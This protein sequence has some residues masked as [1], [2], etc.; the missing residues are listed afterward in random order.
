VIRRL[1]IRNIGAYRSATVAFG[2]GKTAILGENGAGKSTLAKCVVMA[3]QGEDSRYVLGGNLADFIRLGEDEGEVDL[4]FESGGTEYRVRRKWS[5]SG[6]NEAELHLP[7]ATVTGITNVGAEI[8]KILAFPPKTWIDIVWAKQGEITD[9]LRGDKDVFDR[10]LGIRD[11]EEA[12]RR[13]REVTSAIREDAGR[14]EATVEQL[15]RRTSSEADI[16]DHIERVEAERRRERDELQSLDLEDPPEDVGAE[17]A[18]EAARGERIKEERGEIEELVRKGGECPTCGQSIGEKHRAELRER[19]KELEA[20]LRETEER[21]TRLRE[22]RDRA[23]RARRENEARSRRRARLEG[24]LESSGELLAELRARAEQIED[25]KEEMREGRRELALLEAE[26]ETVALL[27]EA[28]RGAQPYL[29]RGRIRRLER[30]VASSFDDMFGGRFSD[31]R[32]DEE[33]RMSVCEQGRE[34]GVSTVSGGESVALA[35]ALRLSVVEE[36]GGQDLLI[37][38]EP[39]SHL[40]DTRVAQLSEVL[41]RLRTGKQ[42][43]LITHDEVLAGS[44]DGTVLVTREAGS[45]RAREI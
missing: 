10:I 25:T 19:L 23:E 5:R 20:E 37:L 35:I 28:Y 30:G 39:T 2:K 6:R 17:L 9:L 45:S 27:R 1:S 41:E 44:C 32:I 15:S 11:L 29:R 21:L 42:I 36:V 3:L 12:W 4:T 26:L 22:R 16:R 8:D 18:R 40:D 7:D 38:D 24:S 34:R 43:L 33:Y 13:L 31:F 14:V